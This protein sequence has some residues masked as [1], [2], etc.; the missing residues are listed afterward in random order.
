[1][2]SKK[3]NDIKNAPVHKNGAFFYI[4]VFPKV[5]PTF[6]LMMVYAVGD[7]A[8]SKHHSD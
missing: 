8:G 7:N 4:P 3:I 1:V 2:L 6:V 5:K